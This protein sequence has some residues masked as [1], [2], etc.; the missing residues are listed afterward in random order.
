MLIKYVMGKKGGVGDLVRY[1]T[2]P[3]NARYVC[4]ECGLFRINRL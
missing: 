4:V 2:I 3:K 1:N